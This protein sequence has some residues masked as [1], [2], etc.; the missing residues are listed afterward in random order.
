MEELD[1]NLE[2]IR[3]MENFQD[4]ILNEVEWDFKNER[5]LDFIQLG[6]VIGR[7][8]KGLENGN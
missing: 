4:H 5:Y 3:A 1:K 8:I 6:L 7:Y 2:H